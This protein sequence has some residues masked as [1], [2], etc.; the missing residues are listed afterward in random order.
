MDWI[1]Y[2]LRWFFPRVYV[3][4]NTKFNKFW[5]QRCPDSKIFAGFHEGVLFELIEEQKKIM[6]ELEKQGHTLDES[7]EIARAV[8]IFDDCITADLHH[9][10][11]LKTLYYEGRHLAF[12]VMMS[13][14]VRRDSQGLRSHTAST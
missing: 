5:Q 3:F 1:L 8:I 4:T 14:Q 12:C 2:N 10:E 6:D 11:V 7:K 9:S 13:L